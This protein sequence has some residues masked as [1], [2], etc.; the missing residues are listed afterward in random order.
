MSNWR[1]TLVLG[2][3]GGKSHNFVVAVDA[4]EAIKTAIGRAGRHI[5]D[6]K[7][8]TAEKDRTGYDD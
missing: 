2:N 1:V 5:T 4:V 8:V 7:M 3:N 6:C